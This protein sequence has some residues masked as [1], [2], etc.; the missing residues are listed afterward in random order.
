MYCALIYVI[1]IYQV[2]EHHNLSEN[3][4]KLSVYLGK[5]REMLISVVDIPWQPISVLF[6][7]AFYFDSL[8]VADSC[9]IVFIAI[10]RE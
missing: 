9:K 10:I 5:R 2:I 1:V 7:G 8:T 6:D 4:G 3:F